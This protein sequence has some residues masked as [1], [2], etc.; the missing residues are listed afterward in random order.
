MHSSF[1]LAYVI[2]AMIVGINMAAASAC[3]KSHCPAVAKNC[4]RAVPAAS[5]PEPG[6]EGK[7]D[8]KPVRGN[9]KT[10]YAS[11]TELRVHSMDVKDQLK[12]AVSEREVARTD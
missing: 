12:I 5:V 8:S 4:P 9:G 7:T 2:A 6:F 10:S 3:D 11:I 1:P